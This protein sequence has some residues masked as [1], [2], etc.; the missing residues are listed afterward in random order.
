[1]F[2]HG[3]PRRFEELRAPRETGA[4]RPGEENRRHHTDVVFL[5]SDRDE[6]LRYAGS[7]GFLYLVEAP[8]AQLYDQAGKRRPKTN[9]RTYIADPTEC[10]ILLRLQLAPRRRNQAQEY[11]LT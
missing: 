7:Q 3:S 9:G 10:R 2:Y 8:N 4:L 6:A 1:M 11:F 5:T